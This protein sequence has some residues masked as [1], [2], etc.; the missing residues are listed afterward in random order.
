[1]MTKKEFMKRCEAYR[2]SQ[3]GMKPI[4]KETF[5]VMREALDYTMS[6]QAGR[7]EKAVDIMDNINSY[8]EERSLAN[9]REL[10]SALAFASRLSHPCKKCWEDPESWETRYWFCNH[11]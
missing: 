5:I 8:A 11:K 1:M 4:T 3:D 2:D 9:F 6:M 10:Y 7:A